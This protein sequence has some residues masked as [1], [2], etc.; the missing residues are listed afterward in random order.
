M[1]SLRHRP[2]FSG[3]SPGIQRDASFA[4]KAMCSGPFGVSDVTTP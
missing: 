2:V 3:K 1:G 4:G